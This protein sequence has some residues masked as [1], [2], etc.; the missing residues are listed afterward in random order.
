M[1]V[2]AER[3][4]EGGELADGAVDDI[5]S[6]RMVLRE[7][8]RFHRDTHGCGRVGELSKDRLASD[9]DDLIVIGNVRGG[10]DEVLELLAGHGRGEK[11]SRVSRQIFQRS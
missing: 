1:S 3:L 11:R 8:V 7:E 9:H 6:L 4:V 5:G 2:V 10:A